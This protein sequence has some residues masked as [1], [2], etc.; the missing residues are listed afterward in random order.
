MRLLAPNG[1][2]VNVSEERAKVLAEQGYKP[3]KETEK[4]PAKKAASSKKQD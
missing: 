4:A 1:S 2:T 3:A